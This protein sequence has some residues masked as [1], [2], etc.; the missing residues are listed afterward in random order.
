MGSKTWRCCICPPHSQVLAL[1]LIASGCGGDANPSTESD[2]VPTTTTPTLG[3]TGE[4]P[5]D[6]DSDTQ[7]STPATTEATS[8]TATPTQSE[9]DSDSLATSETDTTTGGPNLDPAPTEVQDYPPSD[10]VVVNPERGPYRFVVLTENPDL[11][12][13]RAEGITLVYSYVRLDDYREQD[14]GDALLADLEA[15]LDSAREAGVKVILRFAYN[16]GPYPDSEPDAPLAWVPAH[17]AQVT[18]I[19]EEHVDVIAVVQAGF[20]GAWG[21]WH[22][23]TNNLL[24]DK[25]TILSALLAAVPSSR[26]TQLRYPVYKDE[27]YGGP[28]P[29]QEAYSELDGARVGHHNDCFLASDT[30]LGTYPEDAIETW[31]TFVEQDTPYLVMGGETCADNPPRSSC[32]PALE[33]FERF[34]YSFINID[35]HPDVV[36]SWHSD[37]CYATI[38][39]RL[40]YRFSLT[41][42]ERASTARPGGHHR[43]VLELDNEGWAAPYNPRD[44]DVVLT[45]PGGTWV[46]PIEVDPRSFAPG[47]HH[48]IAGDLQLPS[49]A[50]AGTYDLALAL[51]DPTASLRDNPSYAIAFANTTWQAGLNILGSIELD[52]MGPGGAGEDQTL[53]F[54]LD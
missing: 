51:P 1:V 52:P 46:A 25:D 49:D 11:Q 18:P 34:H 26:M 42:V 40:G 7:T 43:F 22:T 23:S 50:P 8:T 53:A 19:L 21:E 54:V 5:T 17:I 45:G 20:I 30:D 48:V 24:D 4:G 31:K 13:I 28:L 16:E 2:T 3:S 9:T 38:D 27:L 39:R 10:A 33:E 35:Y 32:A 47:Q 6:S 29:E 15:G 44:F 12:A 41:S 14:I 36:D 37:G